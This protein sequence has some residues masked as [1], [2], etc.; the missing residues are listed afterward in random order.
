MNI[1]LLAPAGSYRIA[2]KALISG[3]DA[4]Y[5]ATERFGARAYAKNL[6]LV[7]LENIVKIA[8]VLNKKI[9]VTVNTLAKDDE[10]KD[11]FNYLDVLNNLHVDGIITTDPAV[12][13]YAL[14]R[15]IDIC[16]FMLFMFITDNLFKDVAPLREGIVLLELIILCVIYK[17]N[18]S[19]PKENREYKYI[20]AMW[21]LII[22]TL[23][24]FYWF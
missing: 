14:K 11:I 3:A 17:K 1:E 13:D 8:K 20:Y 22:A 9:Y 7:E 4:V 23:V 24:Y 2:L 16:F 5:L 19:I 18:S 6:T 12:I 10:L 15:F 21:G